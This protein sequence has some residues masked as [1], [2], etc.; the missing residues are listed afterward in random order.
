MKK[1]MVWTFGAVVLLI[2]TVPLLVLA[3]DNHQNKTGI[4]KGTDVTVTGYISDSMCGLDHS[5]MMAKH[6]DAPISEAACVEACVKGGA[7]YILADR[8]AGKTYNLKD[9]KRVAGYAGKRVEIVGEMDEN[10]V[11][12]IH[13][14]TLA[15]K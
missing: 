3:D 12:D 7:K 13:K 9:Q 11:L 8:D 10:G 15:P 14:L 4:P 5:D 2:L 1:T 6:S